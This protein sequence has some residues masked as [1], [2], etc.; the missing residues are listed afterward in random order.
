MMPILHSPGVMMPGQLG[1][2]SRVGRPCRMRCTRTMSRAGMPSVMHTTS[3]TPAS[4]ASRIASAA[5]GGGTKISEALAPVS[6]DRVVH[7]VEDRHAVD[8]LA[9]LARGD[10]GHDLGAV[11]AALLG[12]ETALLAGDALDD[13][14]GVRC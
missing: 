11:L 7:R 5:N 1:P 13:D 14:L 6:V 9:G 8:I 2:I 12:V 10:A 3:S 4:A